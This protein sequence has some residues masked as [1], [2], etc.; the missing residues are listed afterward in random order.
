MEEN[1]RLIN[2]NVFFF[3]GKNE[4]VLEMTLTQG[5]FNSNLALLVKTD[6]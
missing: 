5:G 2:S 6:A 4:Q 3:F 1:L